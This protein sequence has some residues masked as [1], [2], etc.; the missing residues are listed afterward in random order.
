MAS[1]V[2]E[3]WIQATAM[4]E[5]PLGKIG[6]GFFVKRDIR[7]G[8][9]F[10]FLVTN[11]HVIGGDR[12]ERDSVDK[13]WVWLNV[14]KGGK[15]VAGRYEY[16]GV[17]RC[18]VEHPNE[19]VDVLAIDVTTLIQGLPNHRVKWTYYEQFANSRVLRD[20]DITQGEEVMIV[21]YPAGLQQGQT[22]HPLVRQGIIASRIGERTA[23]PQ[24]G[25]S[26]K[27][28]PAFY[29][30]GGIVPGSSGS[31]VVLKPVGVRRKHGSLVVGEVTPWLLGIVS[32]T[33]HVTVG[34]PGQQFQSLAGLGLALDSDEIQR[35]I[36]AYPPILAAQADQGSSS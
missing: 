13:I 1:L 19:D 3:T 10:I 11:K 33:I 16:S 14:D 31:P 28:L 15:T 24:Q 18:T 30:D 20:E 7:N 8:E 25:A 12:T 21:G 17:T 27:L 35:T 6:S 34:D 32:T 4:V 36:E 2:A 5:T 22:A 9:G 26:P 29:I 23:V